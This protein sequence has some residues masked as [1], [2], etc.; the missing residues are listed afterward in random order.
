MLSTGGNPSGALHVMS[1]QTDMDD[2]QFQ[3]W[4]TLLEQRTGMHLGGERKSFL[5]T[6]LKIRMREL[7][8]EQYQDYF[9]FLMIGQQG[10]AEWAALVDRLT[11]HETRFYRH[12]STL[13]LLTKRYLPS[14]LRC[15]Q[16]PV[17]LDAWSVGC[18]TGEEPYSLAITLDQY[19]HSQYKESYFSVT[20]SDISL[21]AL[22]EARAGI[23][24]ARNLREVPPHILGR[25][26]NRKDD[27]R[28]QVVET[29]RKRVCVN[30]LNVVEAGKAPLG[31][32]DIILCQNLL[33]YFER[34]VR[35]KIINNLIANLKPGGILILGVGEALGWSSRDVHRL[36]YP[37]TLAYVRGPAS[38]RESEHV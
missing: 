38:A 19:L 26:F 7:G 30:H 20:A 3:Q 36:P 33:I 21:P 11:V 14:Y 4:C 8:F 16:E 29:L 15:M 35:H 23:Y 9:N 37:D 32:M 27:Q 24:H 5:C 22:A 34:S 13:E 6:N 1:K 18:A 2:Q 25:Y 28:Y 31:M 12:P 10:A 17:S